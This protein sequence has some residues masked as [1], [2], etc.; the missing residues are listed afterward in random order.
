MIG[1]IIYRLCHFILGQRPVSEVD[2][3]ASIVGRYIAIV[4]SEWHMIKSLLNRASERLIY[5]MHTASSSTLLWQSSLDA[6]ALGW[7]PIVLLS[8]LYYITRSIIV[9]RIGEYT[10]LMCVYVRPACRKYHQSSPAANEWIAHFRP[11]DIDGQL[12]SA[13]L[14]HYGGTDWRDTARKCAE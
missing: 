5:G 6:P 1:S 9:I 14:S 12:F 4:L 11:D 13:V 7:Q 8:E 3:T 10:Q 2:L